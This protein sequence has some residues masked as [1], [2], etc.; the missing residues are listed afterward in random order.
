MSTIPS[1]AIVGLGAE[2]GA[3]TAHILSS[4]GET[5]VAGA[6][7]WS[8][9]R[10]SR[11]EDDQLLLKPLIRLDIAADSG[12]YESG[13]HKEAGP[14]RGCDPLVGPQRDGGNRRPARGV[15]RTARWAVGKR[16]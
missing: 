14:N 5:A 13:L 9:N 3:V 8:L 2:P 12:F 10:C 6:T 15:R 1:R 11:P 7:R 4:L 16:P